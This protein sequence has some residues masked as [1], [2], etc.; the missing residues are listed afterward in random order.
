MKRRVLIVDDVEDIRQMLRFMV[1]REG[2]VIVAEAANGVEAVE[3]FREHRPDV[4]IM[5]IDMPLMT[6]VEA[7]RE[8]RDMG[9][10]TRIVFCSGGYSKFET[11]PQELR[12][13][14]STFLRKPFLP[15]QLYQ[16]LAA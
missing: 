9:G 10:S 11:P 6:G 4:T 16:A 5:D 7:A 2:H 12:S 3:K 13:E 1:E 14:G 8:I 15:A